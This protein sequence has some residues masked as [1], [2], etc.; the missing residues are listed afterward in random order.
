MNVQRLTVQYDQAEDRIALLARDAERQQLLLLTRRLSFRLLESLARGLRQ[1]QGDQRLAQV[2]LEDELLSMKHVL[3]LG[4]VREAQRNQELLAEVAKAK[5]N[6]PVALVR[7]INLHSTRN[8]RIL[9]FRAEPELELARL[10]LD[11]AQ[12]HWFVGRVLMHAQQAEWG[13]PIPVPGWL[14]PARGASVSRSSTGEL[15]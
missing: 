4:A 2:G 9:I 8:G 5:A 13:K 6:M 11:N 14:E 12:L 10:A 15:H 1:Q 7:E 3:A